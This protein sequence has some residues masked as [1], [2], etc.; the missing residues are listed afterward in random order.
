MLQQR[1]IQRGFGLGFHRA[2]NLLR[3][4][5]TD[6]G[7]AHHRVSQHPLQRQLRQRLAPLLC[8]RMQGTDGGQLAGGDLLG[9]EEGLAL[10]A[11]ESAGMPAR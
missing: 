10:A 2:D 3:A 1:R 6:Q 5:G 4:A 9:L 8:Q 11:R 7:T